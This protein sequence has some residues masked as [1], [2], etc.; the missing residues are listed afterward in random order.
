M[1]VRMH[2]GPWLT[3]VLQ[4]MAV[5]AL[6]LTHVACVFSDPAVAT[7]ASVLM[8][9]P[10]TATTSRSQHTVC[11]TAD[12]TATLELRGKPSHLAARKR[13]RQA[14]CYFCPMP[15]ATPVGACWTV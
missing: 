4:C 2:V 8:Q 14:V 15:L 7:N 9:G 12:S 6:P 13:N 11:C 10:N 1:H 3:R 5:P